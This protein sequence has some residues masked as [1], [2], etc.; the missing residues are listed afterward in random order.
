MGLPT[1]LELATSPSVRLRR[2]PTMA[3]MPT[4]TAPMAVAMLAPMLP[5]P[6]VLLSPSVGS[7]LPPP[8]APQSHTAMLPVANTVL[9]LSGLFTTPRGMPRLSPST[10]I[11]DTDTLFPSPLGT[12]LSL[13]PDSLLWDT[14]RLMDTDTTR[15]TT[16]D[17]GYLST[18]LSTV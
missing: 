10:A 15:P 18:V 11:T 7:A 9:T 3:T 1:L 4:P 12:T 17:M 8:S 6:L 2:M 16:G 13:S 5:L 14:P